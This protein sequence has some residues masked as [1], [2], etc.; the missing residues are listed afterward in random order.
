M[1]ASRGGYK[2]HIRK[3]EDEDHTLEELYGQS[4]FAKKSKPSDEPSDKDSKN[5]SSVSDDIADFLDAEESTNELKKSQELK[6]KDSSKKARKKREKR[7]K[8]ANNVRNAV[9]T[10]ITIAIIAGVGTFAISAI[11]SQKT[12]EELS[13][14]NSQSAEADTIYYSPLTGREV[15]SADITK[16]A[17]TCVMI[18]NSTD[19][20]PQSGLTQAGVVYESIAEGGITRFMAIYQEAKPDILGPVRSVRLTFAQFAKP[21]HCSI[22]HVGGSGNALNLIR[23]NSE[24]RDIDQ[25]YNGSY[26]TRVNTKPNGRRV[27]APHNVYT[28]FEKLDALNFNKGYTSSEFNGFLRVNPD[29]VTEETEKNAT[30]IRINISSAAYN[31]V[32]T[33][34]ANN[35]NYKRS[36]ATGQSHIDVASNGQESQVSPDVVIALKTD[37]YTRSSENRYSDY[38]TIGEND[39]FIFQ[40]GTVVAGKWRRNDAD[41]E[42]KLYTNEGDEIALNRGQVWISLY[43]SNSGSVNWE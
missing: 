35:N 19:S 23:N 24:F 43:P 27:Y 39:V 1:N 21:Y 18:E 14:A 34:D 29:A 30:T 13:D 25:F 28:D 7:E 40:N 31:P 12:N 26:Y 32:Y 22:A 37:A 4:E 33:Y 16:A 17:A 10:I 42:L 2:I 15:A 3:A 8:T 20:R 9:A 5:A 41:S 6:E 38:T 36:Y 11:N